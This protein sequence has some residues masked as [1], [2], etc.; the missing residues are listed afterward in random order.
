MK[1]ILAEP[2]T[3]AE[4]AR[5]SRRGDA[6]VGSPGA[7][8][9]AK[10][11]DNRQIQMTPDQWTRIIARALVQVADQPD[12]DIADRDQRPSRNSGKKATRSSLG[13]LAI[14]PWNGCVSH[15]AGRRPPDRPL[16][17]QRGT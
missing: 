9:A 8:S 15:K 7:L 16:A 17:F 6:K 3:C 1:T 10:H 11:R 12:A 2:H 13:L 5:G 14:G 4:P